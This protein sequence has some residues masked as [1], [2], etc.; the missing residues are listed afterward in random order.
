MWWNEKGLLL[1]PEYAQKSVCCT[2]LLEGYEH[3][4]S[5]FA[6]SLSKLTE[7]EQFEF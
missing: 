2:Y 6:N 1:V 7:G 3:N 4:P 5:H